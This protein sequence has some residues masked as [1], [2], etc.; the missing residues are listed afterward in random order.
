PY[1]DHGFAVPKKAPLTQDQAMDLL[2]G[3]VAGWLDG[4]L[5]A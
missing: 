4:L 5:T 1:A 3:A 2:T